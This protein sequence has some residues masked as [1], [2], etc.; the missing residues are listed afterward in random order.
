MSDH[1]K[2][3][4]YNGVLLR[5]DKGVVPS[6]LTVLPCSSRI[7]GQFQATELDLLPL[8]NIKPFGACAMTYGSPCIPVPILWTQV[9][10][11]ALRLGPAHA[12][13]LLESSVCQCALGGRISII[14]PPARPV[15]TGT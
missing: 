6:P 7:R 1:G 10:Q 8:V 14:M 5:C 9:H 15:R 4:V 3:Y 11:G 2:Q 12:R 13:P